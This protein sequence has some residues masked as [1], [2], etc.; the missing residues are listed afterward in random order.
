MAA[1]GGGADV[2]RQGDL[3]CGVRVPARQ[4]FGLPLL[5]RVLL[6]ILQLECFEV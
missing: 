5:E 1:Y 3:A 2:A 6:Q 4:R